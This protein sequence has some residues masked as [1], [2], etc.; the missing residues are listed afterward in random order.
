MEWSKE[1]EDLDNKVE[2]IIK[3]EKK[4]EKLLE[5]FPD[6][7]SMVEF[8]NEVYPYPHRRN[9]ILV[10]IVET[11]D[12]DVLN[13]FWETYFPNDDK[14]LGLKRKFLEGTNAI[15]QKMNRKYFEAD[16][17]PMNKLKAEWFKSG[18]KEDS[19]NFEF[20][21]NHYLVGRD[22][23]DENQQNRESMYEILSYLHESLA[24]RRGE[25][26]EDDENEDKPNQV[27]LQENG[28]FRTRLIEE[29]DGPN[30]KF[31]WQKK[32]NQYSSLVLCKN[33]ED[34]GCSLYE[35]VKN[36]DINSP[37]GMAEQVFE[38][39]DFPEVH[40]WVKEALDIFH[41][42]LKKNQDKIHQRNLSDFF[43]THNGILM[44]S[45]NEQANGEGGRTKED[46]LA[47][48]GI[49]DDNRPLVVFNADYM[50]KCDEMFVMK[51]LPHEFTHALD[52]VMVFDGK[53]DSLSDMDVVKFALLANYME[54]D[55]S[56][57]HD[58]SIADEIAVNYSAECFS[59]EF[60]A[61]VMEN[62]NFKDNKLLK[63]ML[64][65]VVHYNQAKLDKNEGFIINM[66]GLMKKKL[67]HYEKVKNLNADFMAWQ[68]A[69]K[70][71]E[72]MQNKIKTGKGNGNDLLSYQYI[73]KESE[74]K[75]SRSAQFL[76]RHFEKQSLGEVIGNCLVDEFHRIH[77]QSKK[78]GVI[79]ILAQK[80][81]EVKRQLLK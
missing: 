31:V 13:N 20:K 52:K 18:N 1:A 40:Y 69:K 66:A 21:I 68:K 9:S 76:K 42:V 60:V 33:S 78:K 65:L 23:R 11:N 72:I 55:N 51:T 25:A 46:A 2:M 81:L 30:E 80:Y 27:K 79:S 59:K 38:Q 24:I 5:F 29:I 71:V 28:K 37:K 43:E 41:K 77:N 58:A 70:V 19:E 39:L 54:K 35:E 15:G 22:D 49:L 4:P 44:I 6:A 61:K 48:C 8:S 74:Q 47:Y 45:C 12:L 34:G 57:L 63:N 36:I 16:L 50:Q 64:R 14:D 17:S 75:F 53:T 56:S 7:K 10:M 32:L 3:S 62:R 73:V 67:P 26:S